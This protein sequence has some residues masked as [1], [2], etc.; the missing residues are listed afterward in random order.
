MNKS[1]LI[2]ENKI[3][4]EDNGAL[5]AA[6]KSLDLGKSVNFIK[7]ITAGVLNITK[8]TI[9]DLVKG[10]E[11]LLTYGI[12]GIFDQSFNDALESGQNKRN[13]LNS[14]W[15]RLKNK[16]DIDRPVQD[17]LNITA[18]SIGIANSYI[19]QQMNKSYFSNN[20][21]LKTLMSPAK[22]FYSISNSLF[23]EIS[24][25]SKTPNSVLNIK[26]GFEKYYKWYEKLS[27]SEIEKINK[28]TYENQSDSN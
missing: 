13:S 23:K 3:I 19:N 17:F 26:S 2:T 14:E 16:L 24:G 1:I 8:A 12:S 9:T 20:S 27:D 5:D 6:S 15:E 10:A 7:N 4:K 22:S 11:L 18:P 21:F 25:K 28:W